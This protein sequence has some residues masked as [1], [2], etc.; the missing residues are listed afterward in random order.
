MHT[1][2]LVHPHL[3][4]R[5]VHGHVDPVRVGPQPE[6][7]VVVRVVHGV[8]ELL[9][10]LRKAAMRFLVSTLILMPLDF[11]C[12]KHETCSSGIPSVFMNNTSDIW[13]R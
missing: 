4:L 3:E 12:R 8:V 11:L 9:I 5:P 1:S 13:R 6:V 2:V 7:L 10:D